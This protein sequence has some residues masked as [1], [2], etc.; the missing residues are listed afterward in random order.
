M[1][2]KDLKELITL[3]ENSKLR[4]LVL[5][6][7]DFEIHLEKDGHMSA[8][9]APVR[10]RLST[11]PATEAV[12][13]NKTASTKNGHYVDSPMVGTYYSAPAPDQPDFVKVGDRVSE[14]STVC[15]IEAMKVMNEVKAGKAGIVEEVLLQPGNPVEFGTKLF[16]IV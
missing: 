13:E 1:E 14:D 9:P 3:L 8:E 11:E 10:H 15:I 2:K 4:K 7:K 12:S 5:K 16:R 6:E